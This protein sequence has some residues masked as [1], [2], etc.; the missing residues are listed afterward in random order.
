[1]PSPEAFQKFVASEYER[2]GQIVRDRRITID[3]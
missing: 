1:M 3:G 2:Y